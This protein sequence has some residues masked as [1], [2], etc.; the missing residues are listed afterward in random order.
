MAQ[1]S[2]A[3]ASDEAMEQGGARF[4]CGSKAGVENTRMLF[5][6]C[7]IVQQ[8][9]ELVLFW[10]LRVRPR[11][12][13][14]VESVSPA[15]YKRCVITSMAQRWIRFLARSGFLGREDSSSKTWRCCR[16]SVV[17]AHV[18]STPLTVFATNHVVCRNP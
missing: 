15:R 16:L 17:L 1:S 12:S 5:C 11:V 13:S 8:P 18:Q 9:L 10:S 3:E 2:I 4:V 14:E 6:G 7:V